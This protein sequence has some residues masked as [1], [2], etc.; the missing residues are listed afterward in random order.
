VS[1][2]SH[3]LEGIRVI[4]AATYIAAP[5]AAAILGDFGAEVIKIERPP[6]GDPFRFLSKNPAMPASSH[7]YAFQVDNRNKRSLGINLGTPAGQ[8]V[9]R[10]LVTKADVLVTNY[11]PQMQAKFRLRYEDLEPLNSRLV[12]AM[13]TGYG[14]AGDEAEKP[15]YDTTAYYARSGLMSFLHYE[16]SDPAL[17]P[18]C[19]G[20][21]PTAVS[22]FSAIML[23][24]YRRQQTG[25]GGKVWTTLV[26]NG[27]WSNSSLTQAALVGDAVWPVKRRR[28]S[29]HNPLVNHYRTS[30]GYRVILCLLDADR[31]WTRLCR[32]MERPELA[33]DPEHCTVDARHRN[34]LAVIALLDTEIGR[35]T[36]A[37]WKQRFD[38]NEVIFGVVPTI[39]E[40]PEDP[41]LN[42]IGLFREVRDANY[43][44]VDSPM[45]MDGITKREP[46][47]APD[48]GQ[49]THEI[50]AELGYSPA[51]IDA[52]AASGVL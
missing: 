28:E 41:Q 19:F 51:E 8:Q 11:Q 21:H 46:T 9:F 14:E 44:T 20:D 47:L 6:H 29:A 50:L 43:R 32:A 2:S 31:D 40:L 18:C 49:H 13:V 17:S 24:L 45:Q 23:A 42:S 25:K 36:L 48:P 34:N 4:D 22:L 30:D 26:H 15:G 39:P 1:S 10:Q 52:L 12:Y 37:E 3:P 35:H 16:G 38:R 27:V 7:N 33:A 5:S